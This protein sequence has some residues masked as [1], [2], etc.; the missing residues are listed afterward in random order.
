MPTTKFQL[1]FPGC[2]ACLAKP[3]ER[4]RFGR[5]FAGKFLFVHKRYCPAESWECPF[6]AADPGE[7]RFLAANTPFIDLLGCVEDIVEQLSIQEVISIRQE[8]F[9]T[10]YG[11]VE[12]RM[13]FL[14]ALW[15]AAALTVIRVPDNFMADRGL[16]QW[17]LANETLDYQF[18]QTRQDDSAGAAVTDSMGGQQQTAQV[19]ITNPR[20]EHKDP[21]RK[22]NYP[23]KAF[24][25]DTI[26]LMADVQGLPDDASVSFSMYDTTASP[27]MRMDT[28]SGTNQSGTAQAQWK[29]QDPRDD[30]DDRELKLEFEAAARSKTTSRKEISVNAASFYV[31]LNINP[32]DEDSQNDTF[33]LYSTDA[34]KSFSQTLTVQDD[35]QPGD[36]YTELKFTG[37]D[38][39]LSYSLEIDLEKEGDT[40]FLFENKPYGELHGSEQ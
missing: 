24:F 4:L 30:D 33:T 7:M 1:S 19:N 12:G 10:G 27:P 40:F 17:L 39:D 3:C 36:E 34:A 28:V 15:N 29:V 38:K 22:K 13:R 35:Q 23:S 9:V 5:V 8:Q 32:D 20:W 18:E 21:D 31:R 25:D 11:D 26:V 16:A 14:E 37:L 2:R 6:V